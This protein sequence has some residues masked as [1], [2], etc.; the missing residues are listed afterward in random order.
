MTCI[1]LESSSTAS[2]H[3]PLGLPTGLLGPRW[4]SWLRHCATN[5]QVAGSMSV[6]FFHRHNP[7]GSTMA[8]GSTQ[9]LTEMST[10]NISSGCK[11]GRCVGLTTYHPHVATC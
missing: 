10:R 4:R 9:P 3:L 1:F 7:V 8:L 2:T 11:H 5:R 6:D